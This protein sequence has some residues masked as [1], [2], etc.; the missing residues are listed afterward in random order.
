MLPIVKSGRASA[1]GS[2]RG[3]SQMTRLTPLERQTPR[4]QA[5]ADTL[6]RAQPGLNA[7]SLRTSVFERRA[8]PPH[9]AVVWAYPTTMRPVRLCCLTWTAIDVVLAVSHVITARTKASPVR[10]LAVPPRSL[11]PRVGRRTGVTVSVTKPPGHPQHDATM[12]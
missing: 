2:G 12:M 6:T 5:R 4:L 10:V 11:T 8:E 7:Q 3:S 1:Y 9:T